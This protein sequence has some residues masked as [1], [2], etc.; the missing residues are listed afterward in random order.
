MRS[1]VEVVHWNPRRPVLPGPLGAKV[2]WLRPVNNFGDIL[3][4]VIVEE[5][6]RLKGCLDGPREHSPTRRIV[7]VGS[8]MH[9]ARSGDVVWGAGVNGK[10]GAE[11]HTFSNLDVRAVRGP[12][13]REFLQ[14]RGIDVPAVYGDPGLLLPLLDERVRRWSSAKRFDLCIVP[15][16][17]D[18]TSMAGRADVISPRSDLGSILRRIAQSRMVVGSSLHGIVIAEAL[19]IPARLVMPGQE[20]RFKYEDY[21]LGTG[22]AGFSPA[23]TV[24]AA[25]AAGGEPPITNW[26]AE[27][28]LDAFPV[29]LW[30]VARQGQ[31][32]TAP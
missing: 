1:S 8:V 11:E 17:H 21:Y 16:L 30:G 14:R 6:A 26:S 9:F 15:N 7:A 27:D 28:L 32:G 25:V 18:Y 13:T 29:D 31:N 22:R 10:V 3:S 2:P 5:V 12:L 24:D 20:H 19:Q 4:P 23:S